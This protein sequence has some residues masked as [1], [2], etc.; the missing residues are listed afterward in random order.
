[1]TVI[2]KIYTNAEKTD[3]TDNT[4]DTLA[5]ALSDLNTFNNESVETVVYWPY[6]FSIFENDVMIM[7]SIYPVE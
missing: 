1:M 5:D 7:N 3:S 6:G 2:R 4:F